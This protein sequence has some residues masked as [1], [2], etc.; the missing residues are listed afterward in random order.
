MYVHTV[1]ITAIRRFPGDET[2]TPVPGNLSLCLMC[3]ELSQFDP[4]MK[5]VKFDI[6]MIPDIV[7]RVDIKAQQNNMRLFW[8]EHPE[9]AKEKRKK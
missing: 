9:L 8:E 1:I 4:D 6:N 3:C 2:L 5:L 7:V